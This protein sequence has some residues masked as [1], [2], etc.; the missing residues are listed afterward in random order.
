MCRRL[1]W[2]NSAAVRPTRR[3]CSLADVSFFSLSA[4][5]NPFPLNILSYFWKS[6]SAEHAAMALAC[7]VRSSF[8]ARRVAHEIQK[9]SVGRTCSACADVLVCLLSPL[10]DC[11]GTSSCSG[12]GM[13]CRSRVHVCSVRT[14]FS[15]PHCRQRCLAVT[16]TGIFVSCAEKLLL[17]SASWR[18]QCRVLTRFMSLLVVSLH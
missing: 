14:T 16:T 15:A 4:T 6:S 11:C 5:K 13:D 17:M 2:R 1:V 12:T 18:G 10:V 3:H 7:R 8:L 9:G